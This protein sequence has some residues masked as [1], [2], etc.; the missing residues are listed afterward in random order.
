VKT[1]ILISAL[2]LLIFCDSKS[3]FITELLEYS[4]APG[5]LINAAPWGTPSGALSIVGG[6]NGTACLGAFGGYAIFRF[7][8]QRQEWSGL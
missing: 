3:Q 5:Q 6:V 8:H 7:E 1:G 2:I 4:P